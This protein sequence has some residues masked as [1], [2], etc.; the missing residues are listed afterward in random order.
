MKY[1]HTMVRVA[2]LDQSLDFYCNKLGLVEIKRKE[3]PA[4]R[5]TLVFLAAP[6]D[7]S[8]QV[9][10]TW[11]EPLHH[12]GLSILQYAIRYSVVGSP[13]STSI[14]VDPDTLSYIVT[15]LVDGTA[16]QF[17]VSAVYTGPENGPS[18]NSITATPYGPIGTPSVSVMASCGSASLTWTQPEL[19]GH[20]FVEYIVTW[21]NVE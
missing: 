15:G 11:N 17:E 3:V 16:Y 4:G 20:Q 9:E 21:S 8:A 6:G 10:L 2:D 13:D 18:S 1:L 19:G 5:F 7:E 12:D 14:L